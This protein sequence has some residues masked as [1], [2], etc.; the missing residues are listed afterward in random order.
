MIWRQFVVLQ[1]VPLE[2]DA[3]AA[4]ANIYTTVCIYLNFF[5]RKWGG[6]G[7][8]A[9]VACFAAAGVQRQTPSAVGNTFPPQLRGHQGRVLQQ[10]IKYSQVFS[11]TWVGGAWYFVELW[12]SKYDFTRSVIKRFTSACVLWWEKCVRCAPV[13]ILS[14]GRGG[15]L[16]KMR[17]TV[18]L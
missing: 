5:V 10:V 11:C 12:A 15:V 2:I 9:G 8:M 4:S 3:H 6:W 17:A 18:V 16:L 7:K 1:G 14:S 13:I